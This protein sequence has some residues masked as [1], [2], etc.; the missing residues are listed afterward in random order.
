[1]TGLIGVLL[2]AS[3]ISVVVAFGRWQQS[4]PSGTP[5]ELEDVHNET[6][7]YQSGRRV[8]ESAPSVIHRRTW[9]LGWARFGLEAATVTGPRV[10]LHERLNGPYGNV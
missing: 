9:R 2:G 7:T 5:P 10:G 4:V 8:R 6:P 1:L 3:A